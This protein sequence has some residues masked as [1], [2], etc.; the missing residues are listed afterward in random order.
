MLTGWPYE[1]CQYGQ[2]RLN[3]NFVSWISSWVHFF[4][5]GRLAILSGSTVSHGRKQPRGAVSLSTIKSSSWPQRNKQPKQKSHV[6]YSGR[7]RCAKWRIITVKKVRSVNTLL[8]RRSLID[9]SRIWRSTNLKR[10]A[11]TINAN[12]FWWRATFV[13][14]LLVSRKI[15]ET[16]HSR[17]F[18]RARQTSAVT[19]HAISGKVLMHGDM[20]VGNLTKLNNSTTVTS[21]ACSLFEYCVHHLELL[22]SLQSCPSCQQSPPYQTMTQLPWSHHLCVLC[23]CWSIIASSL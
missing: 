9:R 8:A 6:R 19:W 20:N 3:R 17:Q 7:R 22:T 12:I 5:V 23:V 11:T 10:R 13:R 16:H 21:L 1:E 2:G 14:N 15:L 18:T 4:Y